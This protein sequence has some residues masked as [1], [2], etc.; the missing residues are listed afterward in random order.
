[1]GGLYLA[2]SR[3]G[4][5]II[6]EEIEG[7]VV[8]C[9]RVLNLAGIEIELAQLDLKSLTQSQQAALKMAQDM[10]AGKRTGAGDLAKYIIDREEG[11]TPDR[12]VVEGGSLPPTDPEART[13]WLESYARME[14]E[15]ADITDAICRE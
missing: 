15:I 4:Q 12:H 5:V 13:K 9:R 1:M 11:K 10:A 2:Q 6:I 8:M 7:S 14:L 3:Q